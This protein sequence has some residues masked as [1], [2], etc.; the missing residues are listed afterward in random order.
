MR[1]SSKR[2]RQF[3]LGL[4]AAALVLAT[5]ACTTYGY[6]GSGVLR[7]EV[8]DVPAFTSLGVHD[9]FEFT[10]TENKQRS[11]HDV[12]LTIDD[13]LSRFVTTN[14]VNGR[15]DVRITG[16]IAPRKLL[17]EINGPALQ[18][19]VIDT[20]A[21]GTAD[22]LTNFNQLAFDFSTG[23]S[24]TVQHLDGGNVSVKLASGSLLNLLDGVVSSLKISSLNANSRVNAENLKAGQVDAVLTGSSWAQV[25]AVNRLNV[26]LAENS[27]LFYRGSPQINRQGTSGNSRLLPYTPTP[28][29]LPSVSPSPAS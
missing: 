8:R 3:A 5:G 16:T 19:F 1:N 17:L 4:S 26:D 10:F 11:R 2:L 13:N 15:L 18:G 28:G 12:K 9:N 21:H 6:P 27:T 25:Y 20:R 14:V 22:N 29:V 7:T 23:G 24:M